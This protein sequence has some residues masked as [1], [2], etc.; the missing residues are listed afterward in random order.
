MVEALA[1]V[2][3][4]QIIACGA[5]AGLLQFD[6]QGS[7]L[8]CQ[9]LDLLFVPGLFGRHDVLDAPHLAF[10]RR[11]ELADVIEP[12]Q[13]IYTSLWRYIW[14]IEVLISAMLRGQQF[15]NIPDFVIP[16][17]QMGLLAVRIASGCGCGGRPK[18]P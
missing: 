2:K 15:D 4:R 3:S 16:F 11:F 9:H 1:R 13:T 7:N 10:Q 18:W 17:E 5:L 8:P 14:G 6:L 12:R